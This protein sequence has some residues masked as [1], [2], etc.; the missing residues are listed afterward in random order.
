MSVNTDIFVM[1]S[2]FALHLV[3]TGSHLLA[4]S[5]VAL[6][7]SHSGRAATIY[8]DG[9]GS[10]WNTAAFWSTAAGDA[11]FNPPL[12]PGAADVVN[13]SIS[14]VNSEQTVNL[15]AGQSA[16]GL[17]FLASNTAATKLLGG[18][19][20]RTLTLGS[21][22]IAVNS[23][24]GAVSIGSAAAGQNVM[25]VL[26]GTQTWTNN[27]A[28]L[29]TI[30]NAISNGASTLTVAGTGNTTINGAI[31]AGSGGLTKSGIGILKLAGANT[32]SG[33]IT[34]GGG[35]LQLGSSSALGGS[36]SAAVNITGES[37][38]DLNGFDA[39]VGRIFF[40]S[41]SGSQTQTLTTGL[42][43][44]TI[45]GAGGGNGHISQDVNSA[46][47]K[48]ING[49]IN[50]GAGTRTINS[51]VG[52]WTVNA[53]FS[54]GTLNQTG[55]TILYNGTGT[56]ATMLSGGTYQM[57]NASALGT[58]T[59]TFAGGGISS[60]D[61]TPRT[62]NNTVILSTNGS[63]GHSV[64][65]GKFTFAAGVD[66]GSSGHVLTLGSD[67]D[68]NGN[69]SGSG[70]FV[71]AG[72]GLATLNG[73]GKTLT[74]SVGSNGGILLFTANNQFA[75]N[76]AISVG[77]TTAA[78]VNLNDT[79]QTAAA[80]FFNEG[81]GSANATLTT[82]L[83]TLTITGAQA[84]N[85]AHI[86]GAV[87]TNFA[88]FIN[89]KIDLNGG[90]RSMNNDASGLIIKEQ[91][92]MTISAVMSHG[93]LNILSSQAP[94][95]FSGANTYDLGTTLSGNT[96]RI[97][98]DSVGG[99][100]SITSGA[101][102]T[103][104]LTFNGG[105]LS[106]DGA[107][108]RMIPNAVT[109]NGNATLGDATNNGNLIFSANANLG[110]TIRTLTV[111]SAAQFDGIISSSGGITKTG[112]ATLTLNGNNTYSGT[113]TVSTG[114]LVLTGDNSGSAS[115][116]TLSPGGIGQFNALNSIPGTGRSVT[117]SGT[118]VFGPGYPAVDIP[119]GLLRIKTDSS[120][121][122]AVDNFTGTDFNFSAAGLTNASLGTLGNLTYTGTLTPNGT[123]YR[124]GGGGGT[125]TMGSALIGSN[126]V[127]F[128]G[129]VILQGANT[130]TG[131]TT[132]Y[133]GLYT[134]NVAEIP[135]TSGPFGIPSP[136][137]GSLIFAGGTLQ[138]TAVNTYDYSGRLTATGNNS[139]QIDSNGQ[140]VDFASNIVASGG[141]G[142]T[143]LGAG[144]LTLSGSN[145]FIGG[146]TLNAGTLQ[147]NNSGAL[148]STA[149]SENALTF[150]AGSTGTL[151]LNGNS[152]VVKSLNSNATPGTPVVQNANASPVTLS[153]GNSTNQSG[154]FAGVIKDG[155]GGG[156]LG[157]TK[158]GTG[159]LT[160]GGANTFSGATHIS[161]GTLGATHAAALATTSGIILAS[162]ATLSSG[163]AN[164]DISKL[165]PANGGSGVVAGSTLLNAIAGG[166]FAASPGT[167]Y[168][169]YQ[170]SNGSGTLNWTPVLGA[171]STLYYTGGGSLTTSASIVGD[172]TFMTGASQWNWGSGGSISAGSAGLK[173][174]TFKSQGGI[175]QLNSGAINS[176]GDGSGQLAVTYSG[177][178]TFRT[179]NQLNS[180]TG[181]TIISNATLTVMNLSP[182]SST[183][184]NG[185]SNSSLGA[186]TS[187]ASNLVLDGGTLYLINSSSASTNRLFTVVGGKTSGLQ[188]D[189]TFSFNS[190]GSIS[191]T[192][193]D[194]SQTFN[195]NGTGTG[196]LTP[197]LGDNGAGLTGLSKSGTGI[198]SLAGVNTYSGVTTLSAGTLNLGV[199]EI[200]NVS[201]PLGKSLASN[202]GSIV[203]T[204]GYLQS[205]AVNTNDYSGRF[206]TAINQAYNVD[207][208]GQSV[209]WAAAL[210]S[211]GGSLT[212]VGAG[213]LILSNTGNSYTGA[214]TVSA[215]TLR[216]AAGNVLPDASNVSVSGNAAGVTAMLD[217]NGNSDAIGTLTL[218]GA[219][220]T[221]GA[222]VG[223]GSGTLTLGGNL[224]YSASNNPLGATISG[225]LSL[226]AATR[227][228]AV[229]DSSTAAVD[230][231]V[232]AGISGSSVGLTKTQ[233][234]TLFLTGTNTYTG[235]TTITT[236]NLTFGNRPALYNNDPTK[237]TASNIMVAAGSILGLNVGA[238]ASGYFDTADL[239]TLLN[240]S[241][242][243][244]STPASGMQT[245]SILGLDTSLATSGAFTYNTPIT[246]PGS[247][248]T[249][250]LTKLGNGTLTLGGS[251]SYTGTTN[252][253][254][255]TLVLAGNNSSATG[256]TNVNSGTVLR[257]SA[258]NNFTSGTLTL[259]G[260]TLQLRNDADTSFAKNLTVSANSTIDV[261]Q[262]TPGNT[263]HTLTMGALSI[264][265]QS[266]TATGGNGHALGLGA[267]TLGGAATFNPISASMAVASVSGTNQNLTLAGKQ[268]NNSIGA[269][270]TGNGTLTKFYDD[271]TWTLIGSNTYTGA[272][273]INGGKLI[274]NGST[275]ASSAVTIGQ[276]AFL[277]GTGTVNG[278]VT[279][280]NGGTNSNAYVPGGSIS[281]V[282]GSVGTL[283][284][285]GNLTFSGAAASSA[286]HLFFDLG[287]GGAGAD[288]ITV[289]GT[290]STTATAN[291]VAVFL[292]QLSGGA[293]NAGTHILI[294]GGTAGTN[295]NYVLGTTRAGGNLYSA[296]GVTG[297]NLQ[298]TVGAGTAGDT[299]DNLYWKGDTSAWN[300]A[301]W[302]S[303]PGLTTSTA[304]P[305]YQSNVRIA[306]GALGLTHSFG[307]DYEINSL[308]VDSGVGA[309]VIGNT[310]TRMLTI[311]ATTANNNTANRGITVN[312]AGGA[313]I[314]TTRIG[315]G[316]SQTWYVGTGA[317]LSITAE[318]GD[319]GNGYTLTKDGPGNLTLNRFTTYTGGTVVN[320]GRLILTNPGIADM[321]SGLRGSLTIN[322]G[323]TVVSP[324][325]LGY[326]ANGG[327]YGDQ[328]SVININGGTLDRSGT[329]TNGNSTT[330]G[331]T[332]NMTGGTMS[333]TGT[334]YW[335]F[336]NGLNSQ[337]PNAFNILP[338]GNSSLISGRMTWSDLDL[339]F[340]VADGDA[341]VDL[342]ISGHTGG[343]KSLIKNGDGLMALTANNTTTDAGVGIGHSGFTTINSG[344]LQLGNG[345]TVGTLNP[346][347]PIIN[348]G[349]LAFNRSNTLTQG[350][351]FNSVIS[352][353]GGVTQAGSGTTV[354]TGVNTYTGNTTIKAGTLKLDGGGDIA[355]STRIVVGDA[356]SSGAVLDVTT[357]SGG[358]TVPNGQILSGDGAVAGAV[359]VTGVLS[360]GAAV[361]VLSSASLTFNNASTYQYQ[362]NSAVAN[363]VGADLHKVSGDLNLSGLVTLTLTDLGS[364]LL[365]V[366]T[367]F[368][369]IN[370]TGVWNNGLFT[371]EGN[372]LA[373]HQ[374]F[375]SGANTW[376][377]DYN[378]ADGGANF[379]GDYAGGS[380]SFVNI[381]IASSGSAYQSWIDSYSANLPNA[382]DRQPNA[383]PD[384]DG[385]TN[386]MEFVLGG[387]PYPGEPG[388]NSK[389]LLPKISQTSGNLIFRFN[390][391]DASVGAATLTFQW[392]THCAF[393]VV[394]PVPIGATSSTTDG[395]N[396]VITGNGSAPD[397]IVVTVPAAKAGSGRK[398]FGRLGVSVP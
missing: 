262:A 197:I 88:K 322:T 86:G 214:S 251:N 51:Q 198:W 180:Y 242:L 120:G 183:V 346:A 294:Q 377:I 347:S 29:L 3:R 312:N 19:T 92:L 6:L 244:A 74:G 153:V 372:L 189:T 219:T 184:A 217:L 239:D 253:I 40:A 193:T 124:L 257:I 362:F 226:G 243:G 364:T 151:S 258:A 246:N 363:S 89:G 227:T 77:G 269:I 52:T 302:Y 333:H 360:P 202:P 66:T 93:G 266:L 388:S 35:T 220:A 169:T 2:K 44:L 238:N 326:A 36:S 121:V 27:S 232:S 68:F 268:T 94:I 91:G 383:D 102:G 48:V 274:V 38:L 353:S 5:I 323:A 129:P 280:G 341:A 367:V 200:G 62:V 8:W 60:N 382:S 276:S 26:S 145:A 260:G 98:I 123:T 309:T 259:A 298:V 264:G 194:T 376:N 248:L 292:N 163:V 4:I 57:G 300:T 157:L 316:S 9:T 115:A 351:D 386:A 41:S 233:A 20:D 174:I 28:N 173:T 212:K 164:L 342:E 336:R 81:T 185:G 201:G 165:N 42:G 271:S 114:K 365:S 213:T 109:F 235:V 105:G 110:G 149:G 118:V 224:T 299:V 335:E 30:E 69:I 344:T 381:S 113:T 171:G 304:R 155:S 391:T 230:L 321:G 359:N 366:G 101:L 25:L 231:T 218:G 396:V 225:N 255:G 181:P 133:P 308:T 348:N 305:G 182:Q 72:A 67:A 295:T 96:L 282:N 313:T 390:R 156:S 188:T 154:T 368:S 147:L 210:T 311:D 228:F 236:G 296:L 330:C 56:N 229:N 162:G 187:A 387:I 132:L 375:T 205:S 80:L 331:I 87:N 7:A 293:V 137:A 318:I 104:T 79:N 385:L 301:Q 10:D 43:T 111:N 352:G 209:T 374:Q 328:L 75:S 76:P 17:V 216:S 177:T 350:A 167:I 265:A 50:L 357:K 306:S 249:M 14:T 314:S 361:G 389:S 291:T 373:N 63:I 21:S 199:A 82:G 106:S 379:T 196:T 112:T 55:G 281:L 324:A 237:W 392:S 178:G 37:T 208:N 317:A 22:G 395:V 343:T 160:L 134:A 116:M 170:I 332:F 275:H 61:T 117:D 49:N 33:S 148:N 179:C 371:L 143:K 122:I 339:P 13:F 150:G 240:G 71:K 84:N 85:G 287:N 12:V 130:Y 378:A 23:G 53:S 95:L 47:P 58:G 24:A 99:P 131:A 267:T 54:N 245:N 31:T 398:L 59:L 70:S 97:G 334:G 166:G 270:T 380:D 207:T 46:G 310:D 161:T 16:L 354:L 397:T 126:T 125:L 142:L 176:I 190:P 277:A 15:N 338:S 223:T 65:N 140:N 384:K 144:T 288:K 203:L 337:G 107:A 64:N 39:S 234:G 11:T 158:V 83:G 325:T 349:T 191:I 278:N 18:G 285:G 303:D 370:Y 290:F 394:N 146:V 284:V 90:I 241:H 273:T 34:V 108:S 175:W 315:L 195:L 222:R 141:S 345:G 152:V 159:T 272:T 261:D 340:N 252:I 329:G 356:G 279:A 127:V 78:T 247:A 1:K 211:A 186:S 327:V 393:T 250:G 221:S 254:M 204:G 307:Q 206:S 136:V 263:N 100:G 138:F 320:G 128:N 168:G 256:A 286:N 355:S 215:G 369:L 73:T 319:F 358:F 297:N 32:F 139:Y 119:A 289:G 103:G 172:A 45:T 283:A 135:G 192:G